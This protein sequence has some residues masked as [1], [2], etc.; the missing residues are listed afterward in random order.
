MSEKKANEVPVLELH[1]LH[2]PK[3]A[4]KKGKRRG[5]GEGSGN[6]RQGGRGHKGQHSR[7]GFSRKLGFEGGQMPLVRRIPKRGFTNIYRVEFAEVN[8]DRLE[9]LGEKEI[10]PEVLKSRGVIKN[11]KNPVKILGNG[12]IKSAVAVKAHA[13]SKSAVAKIEAAGGKVE[14]LSAP[15]E[16]TEAKAEVTE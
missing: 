15:A 16:N 6:G 7:S 8:V 10:T 9:A 1:A 3:G 5:Q 4:V 11:L 2:P 12:E 13:F 14:V